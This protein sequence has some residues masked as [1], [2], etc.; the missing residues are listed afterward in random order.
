[1]DEFLP[2][3]E[4]SLFCQWLSYNIDWLIIPFKENAGERSKSWL[5][6]NKS[7]LDSE[8]YLSLHIPRYFFGVYLLDK[9]RSLLI[10]SS[11]KVNFSFVQAEVTSIS[12]DKK[13]SFF[14]LSFDEDKVVNSCKLLLGIGI[15]PVRRL[16]TSIDDQSDLL[17]IH[18]PYEASLNTTLSLISDHFLARKA[19][20]VLIVGA[21]ASSLE[22]LYQITNLSLPLPFE[23]SFT[24]MSPQ[25]SLP[26]LYIKDKSSDFRAI[27]LEDLE[28][29]HHSITADAILESFKKDL[30]F[31]NA[32]KYDISDTLP[33][34]TRHVGSLIQRLSLI[35]K[36]KFIS[37]HGH[38]IGIAA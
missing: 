27:S 3:S 7:F 5:R 38:E 20:N 36:Y 12:Q 14:Q 17:F 21:N 29:S 2:Q 26:S 31:A 9:L 15:P 6:D 24:I 10:S 28:Q 34:F 32:K 25:G 19:S 4:L 22:L 13:S 18:D 30:E 33:V 37:F 35:E 23:P 11:V 8:N 16:N 1:M